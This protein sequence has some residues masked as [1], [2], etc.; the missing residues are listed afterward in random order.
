MSVLLIKKHLKSLKRKKAA[1][2]DDLP[3]GMLKD[4]CDYIAKPPCHIINL[5][6]VNKRVPSEWKKARV[7]PLYKSGP[8]NEPENYRS[9]RFCSNY[10]KGLFKSRSETT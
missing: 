8:V 1:G 7:I 3:P 4:C 10:L 9:Y 5:S 6:L 2:L